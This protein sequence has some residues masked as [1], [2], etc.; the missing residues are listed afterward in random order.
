MVFDS[1]YFIFLAV[2]F[3]SSP[4][5]FVALLLVTAPYGRYNKKGW[6]LTLNSRIA[7]YLM[8][9]PAV[10]T[11]FLVFILGSRNYLNLSIIYLLIW[12]THYIYRSFIFPGLLRG[13]KKTFPAVLVFFAFVFNVMNGFVN[14]YYLFVIEPAASIPDFLAPHFIIGLVLFVTGLGINIHSDKIIRLLRKGSETGYKIPYGGFFRFVSSPNY[15]GEIIEWTG[16]AVLTWSIPGL[17][18]AVF[19]F[20]NLAPRAVSNHKWYNEYFP[21]YPRERKIL[22]PFIF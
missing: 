9:L 13:A 6:G 5:I 16:W 22:F 7:W 11:I 8:E 2:L 14:G 18:F 1:I 10:I 17:C 15:M 4:L 21:D 12:E 20:C 19:T 3:G